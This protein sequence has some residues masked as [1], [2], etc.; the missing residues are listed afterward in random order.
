M[1]SKQEQQDNPDVII[2]ALQTYERTLKE[3]NKP[4]E[5]RGAESSEDLR[6][7][8]S[9]DGITATRKPSVDSLPDMASDKTPVTHKAMPTDNKVAPATNG[10]KPGKTVDSASKVYCLLLLFLIKYMLILT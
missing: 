8:S 5:M 9:D 4:K 7:T 6:S 2:N 3:I 10:H 1:C